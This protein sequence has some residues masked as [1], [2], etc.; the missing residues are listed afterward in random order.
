MTIQLLR[1]HNEQNQGTNKMLSRSMLVPFTSSYS[2]YYN[3]L[4]SFSLAFCF[5]PKLSLPLYLHSRI[6]IYIY[7]YVY[8][9]IYIHISNVEAAEMGLRRFGSY[10]LMRHECFIDSLFQK[11][12]FVKQCMCSMNIPLHVLL[13]LFVAW[14][15]IGDVA[16][17][18]FDITTVD[19]DIHSDMN[20]CM[21]VHVTNICVHLYM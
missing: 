4:L 14:I 15:L 18:Y 1:N 3:M 12:L 19:D 11:Q 6:S 21:C 17:I 5:L 2:N 20:M 16:P 8:I 7:I 13:L 9:Y 10:R